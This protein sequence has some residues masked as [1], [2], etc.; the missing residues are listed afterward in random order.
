MVRW[1]T[2]LGFFGLYVVTL[3]RGVLSADNGEFQLVSSTLGLAHPP[4]FPLYTLLAHLFSKLPLPL[5]PAVK[6]NLFSAVTSTLTLGIIFTTIETILKNLLK[7]SQMHVAEFVNS[8]THFRSLAALIGTA[9]L[10]IATTFWSQATTANIRSLTALFA[11]I[12]FYFLVIIDSRPDAA[13]APREIARRNSRPVLLFA[14]AFGFGFTH[15]LSLAYMGLVMIPWVLWRDRRRWWQLAFGLLG[16]LPLLYLPIVAPNLRNPTEFI[17]Y[18]LGLGFGGD[19]FYFITPSQLWLRTGVMWNVLTFQFHPLLLALAFAGLIGLLWQQRKIG[20]LL[21]ATFF[22]HTFIVATYRAPQTVEYMLPAYLPLAICI[23]VGG[24][25]LMQLIGRLVGAFAPHLQNSRVKLKPQL[26]RATVGLLLLLLIIGQGAA[27]FPSFWWLRDEDNSIDYAKEILAEAPAGA[28]VLSN[29]H[30][31]TPMRYLQ[32]IAGAR[33]DLDVQFVFPQGETVTEKWT[34]AIAAVNGAVVATD[35]HGGDLPRPF[36]DAFLYNGEPVALP[37]DGFT[38]FETQLGEQIQILAFQ[39]SVTTTAIGEEM[40]LT[41]VWEPLVALPAM[42]LFAHLVDAQSGQLFAQDDVP[43]IAQTDGYAVTQLRLTPRLG[44]TPGSYQV[45][46]GGYLADG[47]PLLDQAG[48]PR[49]MATALTVIPTAWRP[50]TRNRVWFG[51]KNERGDQLIGYDFDVTVAP[52]LYLHWQARDG[53]YS[54]VLDTEWAVVGRKE[55]TLEQTHYVPLGQGIVWLGGNG[56]R[57]ENFVSVQE[58][59]ANRPIT[60]DL[61]VG[62]RFVGYEADNTTWAW[63]TQNDSVPATGAIPTLKW[64]AGSSV[65]DPHLLKL[66]EPTFNGQSVA[67]WLTVYDAFTNR[68]IPIL[69][70]RITAQGV[71]IPLGESRLGE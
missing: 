27:R 3:S 60:R 62:I 5:S 51:A 45:L 4:G 39:Q 63:R 36:G 10:G 61:R 22:I 6:I 34:T 13:D 15:H 65:R 26:L 37:L 46:I 11:A 8:S 1:L 20:I 49:T 32:E 40:T 56:V 28:T 70:E 64:I 33:P 43:A 30:W 9:A 55:M 19:F 67:A 47:T 16:L 66:G 38:P 42:N 44:A 12:C 58:F 21:G 25:Y 71:G 18:A 14:L 35:F 59:V 50:F 69:D 31:F 52:R 54:T 29:W 48:E 68:P 23:G 57:G 53:F 17:N 41:L 7:N 2:C 24:W